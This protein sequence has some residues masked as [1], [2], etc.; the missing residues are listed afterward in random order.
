MR[1]QI[2]TGHANISPRVG[3]QTARLAALLRITSESASTWAPLKDV[4]ATKMLLKLRIIQVGDVHYPSAS[5][6]SRAI[7]DKD[8]KFPSSLKSRL[9]SLPLK[10]VV[11]RIHSELSSGTI[12]ALLF[13]G[14]LTDHGNLLGFAKCAEYLTDALELGKGGK[15]QD[16]P[17]GF[18]PGNHDVDRSLALSQGIV[19]KF[20]TLSD[21]M[22][23]VGASRFATDKPISFDISNSTANATIHLLN[24]CWGC[25]EPEHIPT[26]FRDAIKNAIESVISVNLAAKKIYYDR[27]LDTPA[28]DAETIS[29]VATAVHECS[30]TSLPI[31][32]AHHNLLPQRTTRLAPYTELVNSGSLRGALVGCDRPCVYLHGHIHEDPIEVVHTGQGAPLVVISAPAAADGFNIVEIVFMQSGLPLAC[33]IIPFRFLSGTVKRLETR[34]IP[35]IGSRRRSTNRSLARIYAHILN[36]GECFWGDLIQFAKTIDSSVS[37]DEVV[38]IIELLSADGSVLV[39]NKDLAARNWIVRATV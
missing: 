1:G 33:E 35:L 15:F 9:S 5:T 26:E 28:F 22:T 2:P 7:D 20:K 13:M 10:A 37:N 6:A 12:D 16:L 39:D 14:D 8:S 23:A 4:L 24:S 25:G 27:Q 18:V 17:T 30:P 36:H 38:E 34:S 31:L 32:V 3:C 29:S 11:Q 19:G 21:A